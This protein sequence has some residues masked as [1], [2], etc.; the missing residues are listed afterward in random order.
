MPAQPCVHARGCQADPATH[1]VA[2]AAHAARACL[3][4]LNLQSMMSPDEQAIRKRVREY[5][6]SLLRKRG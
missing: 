6:A 4:A 2:P 1:A 5:M 3:A